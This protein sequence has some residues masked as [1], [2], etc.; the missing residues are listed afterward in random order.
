[1]KSNLFAVLRLDVKNTPIAVIVVESVDS[2]KYTEK[3]I[4]K[5]LEDQQD[6]L[7]EMIISLEKFIPKPSNAQLIE[8]M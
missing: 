1:M 7:S 6:Y 2:T 5:F 8:G 3:Q 4:K